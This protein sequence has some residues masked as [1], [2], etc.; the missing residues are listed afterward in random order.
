VD[1]DET[2]TIHG[3]RTEDVEADQTMDV[4]AGQDAAQ[5]GNE[6]DLAF[7]KERA[8]GGDPD[9]P[10]VLGSMPNPGGGETL[11]ET[12]DQV[13]IAFEHGDA[14]APYVVGQLWQGEDVPPEEASILV[15]LSPSV[16]LVGMEPGETLMNLDMAEMDDAG[17]AAD[18]DD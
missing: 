8:E 9:E 17:D 14:H 3:G 5:Q 18:L 2:I 16:E 15:D 7:L 13:T 12:G 4:V 10:L 11:P 6:S 1:K